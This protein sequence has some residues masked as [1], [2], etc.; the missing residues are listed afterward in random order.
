VSW[1]TPPPARWST[2]ATAV[3]EANER[4]LNVAELP[5]ELRPAAA[6]ILKAKA[7]MEVP[8]EPVEAALHQ[9]NQAIRSMRPATL[10]E[11]LE[12]LGVQ[13]EPEPEPESVNSTI[14]EG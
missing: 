2:P 6:A 5:E 3:A 9:L 12:G 14:Q 7:D 11:Q 8:A 1:T 4:G 10:A 13:P